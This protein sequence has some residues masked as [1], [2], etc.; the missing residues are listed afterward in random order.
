MLT[1][2][3]CIRAKCLDCMGGNAAEVRRCPSEE[4][5]LYLLRMGHNPNVK[6][7][8]SDA[9]R[10]AAASRLRAGRLKRKGETLSFSP[11][12]GRD[13]PKVESIPQTRLDALYG[14]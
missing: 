10:E 7:N 8:L 3:K 9:E 14:R 2:L 4:C 1:P 6:R 12:E 13:T 5:P 11:E